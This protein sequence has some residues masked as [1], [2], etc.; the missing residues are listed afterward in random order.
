MNKKAFTL[1]ELLVVIAIV[2]LLGAFLLPTMGR[3]RE[4]ARIAQC[5]NNLRQIGIA[6]YLFLDDNDDMF[7][8]WGVAQLDPPQA[9]FHTWGGKSGSS[10]FPP[11]PTQARVLNRYLDVYSD[12]DKAALEVFHCPSD[13]GSTVSFDLSGTSYRMNMDL[14][15]D[16]P[17]SLLSLT[18]PFSKLIL[19]GDYQLNYDHGQTGYG[20]G[21]SGKQ[22]SLNFV[23]MDG[24]VKLHRWP[25][26]NN[27]G[28]ILGN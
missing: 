24:H 2:G 5:A 18:D 16:P 27:S 10:M 15:K 19:V 20:G 1:I 12:N 8:R 6:W 7:P 14:L 9:I 23:F 11:C 17:V 26:D 22:R 25:V 4:G 21:P 13:R 28:E 3:V